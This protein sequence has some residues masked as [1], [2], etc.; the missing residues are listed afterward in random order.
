MR[1]KAILIY[2]GKLIAKEK[3]LPDLTCE[4]DLDPI[5]GKS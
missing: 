2:G 5:L 4:L 1:N 3:F